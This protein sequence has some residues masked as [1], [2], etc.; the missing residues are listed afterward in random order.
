[1]SATNT[2]SGN[3]W[4]NLDNI[5]YIVNGFL[6][7][8]SIM[9]NIVA[10]HALRKTFS[11]PATL[12]TLFLSLAV[13]DLGVGLLVQPWRIAGLATRRTTKHYRVYRL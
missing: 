13:S 4:F 7:Y 10:I 3:W 2:A 9:L 5:L 6:S 12:K 11:L 8:S 1:M